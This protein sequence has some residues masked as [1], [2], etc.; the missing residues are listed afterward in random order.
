MVVALT[1][2]REQGGETR[3]NAPRP[4]VEQE[5]A[6][7][8]QSQ[9]M[10]ELFHARL[11][12]LVALVIAGIVAACSSASDGADGEENVSVDRFK[13]LEI[14]DEAVVG[15]ARASN[16]SDG[17][18]SFRHAVEHMMPAGANPGEFV[19]AWFE[20]WVTTTKVNGFEVDRP[21]ETRSA[22]MKARILCPWQRRT[23]ANGCNED[24]SVCTA[25][26]PQLDL[27]VAPFR[28]LAIANRMDV[29]DELGH[30][31]NGEAR[32]VFAL[33]G[34][35]GDDPTVPA[36]PM[37]V[38]FEYALPL[39]TPLRGWA[40]SWHALGKHAAF[41][42]AYKAELQAL[43]DRFVSRGMSPSDPNG[44]AISQVRSNESV[45]NWIW[46]LREFTLGTDG[47]LHQHTVL[48]TPAASFNRSEVLQAFIRAN[49][50]G[51][52]ANKYLVPEGLLAGSADQLLFR[53]SVGDVDPDAAAAFAKG[54][55][56]GCHSEGANPSLDTA[57]HISP[58]R[59][60]TASV[61]PY[62]HNPADTEHDELARR[63][64]VL[65]RG[66]RGE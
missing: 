43:T 31:A 29:R 52:K 7:L 4:P 32:L 3:K 15:D 41:D 14:V 6:I 12:A 62:L 18:W 63:A 11:G 27:A 9:A 35:A 16:A 19:R 40:E 66:L 59:K 44:S 24:C 45:L 20:E 28:L 61:S 49:A 25:S 10:R 53:W 60:G 65:R 23:P 39:S 5:L 34:G 46:Q 50:E 54:T 1:S 17:P 57:F 64:V 21:N 30:S 51:L 8:L 47:R 33:T 26:A 56:N 38:I 58:F 42:E 37:T 22:S 13:E 36:M 48:N 55:C 2:A